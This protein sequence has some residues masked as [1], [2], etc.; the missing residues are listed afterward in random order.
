[1]KEKQQVAELTKRIHQLELE[2][3]KLKKETDSEADTNSI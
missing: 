1:M 3:V 2:N